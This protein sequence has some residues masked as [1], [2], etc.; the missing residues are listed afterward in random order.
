MIREK[1]N[2]IIY[3][4]APDLSAL[5][6]DPDSLFIDIE[7]T[8][9]SPAKAHIYMIGLIY[10]Q[11]DEPVFE[12]LIAETPSDEEYILKA[13]LD[14]VS[15]YR[16][17]I[18]FN[19]TTFDLPFIVSRC[20][21]YD[22]TFDPGAYES[23]DIYRCIS[24]YKR[25]L[26]LN[27]CKQKTVERFLGFDREDTYSGGELID[28]YQRYTASK[29]DGLYRILFT[30]NYD[31]LCGMYNI[32]P[33]VAYGR[34]GQDI[35]DS[36]DTDIS[37]YK[38][39]DGLIHKELLIRYTL[40]LDI[41]HP[42]SS[43]LQGIFLSVRERNVL[44]KVPVYEGELKLFYND[45]K[46]YY[47]LPEEDIAIHKSVSAYMDK[48]FRQPATAGNCYTRLTGTFL[49]Q[50]SEFF[51]PVCKSSYES[52]DLYFEFGTDKACD[53]PFLQRYVGHI[54]KYLI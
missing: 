25:L 20:R 36:I 43:S 3:D 46:E 38:G 33:V 28:V 15:G 48:R 27:N 49:P 24:H 26:G 54:L 14:I 13:F 17:L 51:I 35:P 7:T 21:A 11:D 39:Y 41:P 52:K 42:V 16:M 37:E 18:H 40:S 4:T 8:G 2:V 23:L 6:S 31:D 10:I 12:G 29:D 50:F 47:Y 44:I 9:L 30:H 22:L 1:K 53:I 45:P 5:C 19:G 32:L 34:M